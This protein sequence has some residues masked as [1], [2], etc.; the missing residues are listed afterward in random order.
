[1]KFSKWLVALVFVLFAAGAWWVAAVQPVEQEV[2]SNK[3]RRKVKNQSKS[4][5]TTNYPEKWLLT[6][7]ILKMLL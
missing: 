3:G 1:M 5:S 4:V 7:A 2:N 6:A